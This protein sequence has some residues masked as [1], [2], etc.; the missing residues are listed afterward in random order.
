[1]ELFYFFFTPHLFLMQPLMSVCIFIFILMEIGT[2]FIFLLF[3]FVLEMQ[4]WIEKGNV[5]HVFLLLAGEIGER[6]ARW[7]S[8]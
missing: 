8:K 6:G 3:L 5:F 1:M 2:V 4:K 7:R